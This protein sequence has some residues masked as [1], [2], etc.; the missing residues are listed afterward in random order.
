M[1]IHV[2]HIMY[3]NHL[4][5]SDKKLRYKRVKYRISFIPPKSYYLEVLNVDYW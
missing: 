2:E 4:L 3:K 1:N 5:N